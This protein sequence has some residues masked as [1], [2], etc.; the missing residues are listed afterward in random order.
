MAIA[1]AFPITLIGIFW[2]RLKSGRGLGVRT[3]QFTAV[4]MIVPAVVLLAMRGFLQGE[5]VAAIIGGVA[6]YLLS[7]IAK[8]DERER[9]G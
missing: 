2:E 3:I 4:S 1:S 9:D 6:G 5:A 8:F 7:N